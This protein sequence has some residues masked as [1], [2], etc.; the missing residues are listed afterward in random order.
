MRH[1]LIGV[2]ALAVLAACGNDDAANTDASTSTQSSA[3]TNKDYS[4]SSEV[5]SALQLDG[6]EGGRVSFAD[7]SSSAKKLVLEDLTIAGDE[8][9]EQVKVEKLVL[10]GMHMTEAG[11]S[12]DKLT[13][14]GLQPEAEDGV[15]VT[16][17]E[18]SLIEP[19]A[20]TAAFISSLF[21][22]GE[23]EN[24]PAFND[25]GFERFAFKN[26]QVNF[27]ATQQ[28][29]PEEGGFTLALDELSMNDLLKS[30]ADKALLSGLNITFDVPEDEGMPGPIVG[31][32][33]WDSM[34]L[35]GVRGDW[36]E[37]IIEAGD[38]PEALHSL[39]LMGMFNSPIEQGF[40]DAEIKGISLNASGVSFS[41]PK[42]TTKVTRNKDGVATGVKSPEYKM[43]LAADPEGGA[44]GQ[45]LAG[46]LGQLGYEQ[47][48]MSGASE[49]T[50][51]PEKKLTRYKESYIDIEDGLK[52]SFKGGLT[53]LLQ[54]MQAAESVNG[55]GAS[56]EAAMAAFQDLTINDFEL[57][58]EDKS[59]LDRGITL[60]AQMQGMEPEMLKQMAV[61]GLAM[62]TM[63]A[64][65][66]GVDTALVNDTVTALSSLIEESGAVTIKIDPSEPLRLGDIED[67]TSLTKDTL[68]F[69]ATHTPAK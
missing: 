66:A 62:A 7:S 50:Y 6:S 39:N 55:E 37:A 67:P 65:A 69:S 43:T 12:F 30:R 57:T 26:L 13:I 4:K 22:E 68:G 40:D 17:G 24:P 5:V 1:F 54:V 23:P 33:K 31:D 10:E 32:L 2:S 34:S 3:S 48:S 61:G 18:I 56:P 9:S 28:E 20:A 19:N 16:L 49:V 60:A 44:L 52:L 14:T 11:P 51:D 58:L 63:Q 59:I 29:E 64:G 53:N 38:D 46:G 36:M 42:A 41:L 21:A 25:W 35:E 15:T 8:D 45:M 47:I 27:D